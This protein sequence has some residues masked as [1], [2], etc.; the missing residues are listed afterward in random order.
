MTATGDDLIDAIAA[1]EATGDPCRQIDFDM[2]DPAIDAGVNGAVS[3]GY[4]FCGWLPDFGAGDVFRLQWVDAEVTDLR[5]A[6]V[7]PVAQA[8]LERLQPQ[9]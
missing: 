6:V 9:T 7:N 5:P 1:L 8:L 3:A 4:V 2:A